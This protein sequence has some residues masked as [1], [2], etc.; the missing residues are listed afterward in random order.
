[1]DAISPWKRRFRILIRIIKRQLYKVT[2]R[3]NT[4]LQPH[5]LF[6]IKPGYHHAIKVEFF[7]DTPY[8]DEWQRS[9]YE[10]AASLA[11]K[12]DKPS[13]I[14]VGCGSAYKLVHMLGQYEIAGIEVEPT[15]S[16]LKKTY[17]QHKWLLF[18]ETKPS[19][20]KSDII[21]CSDVIEHIEDPDS[22]LDFLQDIDFQYLVLSTPERDS[23]LGKNDYGPPEN[24]AHYREWNQYEFKDYVRG[25]FAIEEQ[26]ILND[27][28]ITQVLVCRKKETVT[29]RTL[30]K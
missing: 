12:L 14:D 11:A 8:K 13:V 23:K 9:V 19:L 28:S 3:Y 10:L 27:K 16:W 4:R 21:I 25:W 15:Y 1:M 6:G 5:K 17:P 22:L 18:D 30:K 24:L 29:N 7:D 26:K 20:L 2:G